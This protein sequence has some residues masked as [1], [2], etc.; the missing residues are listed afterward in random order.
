MKQALRSVFLHRN[1]YT[2]KVAGQIEDYVIKIKHLHSDSWYGHQSW[3]SL[4]LGYCWHVNSSILGCVGGPKEARWVTSWPSST[5]EHPPVNN[6]TSL[7]T[8]PN[9]PLRAGSSPCRDKMI[10]ILPLLK[11]YKK[12][13]RK[14]LILSVQGKI[15]NQPTW[16]TYCRGEESWG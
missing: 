12:F 2:I 8:F 7:S 9:A 3:R 11:L 10:T 1:T 14:D 13:Q 5:Q 6:V 16:L 15:P 4:H